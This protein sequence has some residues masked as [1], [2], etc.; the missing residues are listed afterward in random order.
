MLLNIF[1]VCRILSLDGIC[2]F[3][4]S[5]VKYSL[6]KNENEVIKARNDILFKLG[7][8]Y[9]NN[10]NTT[11]SVNQPESTPRVHVHQPDVEF[12]RETDNEPSLNYQRMRRFKRVASNS[13]ETQAG[14]V[15]MRSQMSTENNSENPTG[16]GRITQESLPKRRYC[17]YFVNFGK[18][19]YEEKRG[20]NVNSHMKQRLSAIK[21]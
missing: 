15:Q 10:K 3:L 2:L 20:P 8:G 18:C 5:Q 1:L 4:D 21:A 13:A 14:S 19:N 6:G 17:N 16:L 9:I 12:L 7:E 11:E